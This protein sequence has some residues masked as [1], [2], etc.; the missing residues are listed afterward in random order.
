M[1]E[2]ESLQLLQQHTDIAAPACYFERGGGYYLIM[3]YM[4]AVS[5]SELP[6]ERQGYCA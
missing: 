6:E 5:I 4:E 3:E 1:N 2:A